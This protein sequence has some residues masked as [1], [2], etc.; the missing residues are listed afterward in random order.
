MDPE[1]IWLESTWWPPMAR[2]HFYGVSEQSKASKHR[3]AD[4]HAL[5][6]E[7]RWRGAMYIA[8]YAVE[9]LLKKKLMSMFSFQDLT[10]LEEKLKRRRLL[11]AGGTI[12]TH[13]LELLLVL[14]QSADR[15]RQNQPLWRQ[16]NIVNRWIPAW[17]YTA[18]LS[19]REDAADF[20]EAVTATCRWIEHNI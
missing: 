17:R 15:L 19:N 20:L 14:T 8:G 7:H 1:W 18:N 12:F 4:A 3:L 6:N 9:C 10:E 16:F 5:F 11:R 13:Q 2:E